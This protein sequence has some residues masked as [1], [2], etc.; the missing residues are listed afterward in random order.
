MAT[1]DPLLV[2]CQTE[3]YWV[4]F[5]ERRRSH[6]DSALQFVASHPVKAPPPA[7][8]DLSIERQLEQEEINNRDSLGWLKNRF[9]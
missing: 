7:I 8:A 4:T 3:R 2:P 5:P 1:R 6:L 9:H